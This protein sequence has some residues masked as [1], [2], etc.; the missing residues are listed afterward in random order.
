MRPV[1]FDE[2]AFQDQRFHLAIHQNILY[3]LYLTHA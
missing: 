1:F 3:I 2:I